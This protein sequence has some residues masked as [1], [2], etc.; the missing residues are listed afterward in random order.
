MQGW[1]T[2]SHHNS[3][4]FV[5]PNSVLN[6]GLS[7]FGTRESVV[8]GYDDAFELTGVFKQGVNVHAS[9]DVFA[10]VT[11]EHAYAFLFF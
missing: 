1:L 3:V 7:L 5:L 4:E 2:C 6:A 10:A 11:N 8:L 9:S